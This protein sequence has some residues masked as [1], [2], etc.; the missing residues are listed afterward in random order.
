M[1]K[2]KIFSAI[3]LLLA[4]ISVVSCGPTTPIEVPDTTI[5]VQSETTTEVVIDPSIP[6]GILIAGPEIA[7]SCAIVFPSGSKNVKTAVCKFCT[8]LFLML[9]KLYYFAGF[10][11][12]LSF[13][14][15]FSSS[16]LVN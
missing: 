14:F 6:E 15:S 12:L 11:I 7:S 5:G 9:V 1:I 2:N 8:P 3:A 4:L 10:L 13:S 16:S